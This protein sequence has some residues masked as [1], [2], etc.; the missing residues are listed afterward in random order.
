MITALSIIASTSTIPNLRC[1]QVTTP[2][3]GANKSAPQQQVTTPDQLEYWEERD[4]PKAEYRIKHVKLTSHT[5]KLVLSNLM[6]L[7]GEGQYHAAA[8]LAEMNRDYLTDTQQMAIQGAWKRKQLETKEAFQLL[9]DAGIPVPAYSSGEV[10][11]IVEFYLGM[12]HDLLTGDYIR[13]FARLD[14]L[15][16]EVGKYYLKKKHGLDFLSYENQGGRYEWDKIKLDF[17][18]LVKVLSENTN[19]AGKS[20]LS[21]RLLERCIEALN[22]NADALTCYRQLFKY[23]KVRNMIAHRI[24]PLDEKA[25]TQKTGHTPGALCDEIDGFVMTL[26]CSAVLQSDLENRYRNM[27]TAIIHLLNNGGQMP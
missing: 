3:N 23:V 21:A 9:N 26:L 24:T 6:G 13:F 17:P 10:A 19:S 2:A 5:R 18:C 15:L 4:N 1:V 27:N 25:M 20:Y 16:V 14:P 8:R 12:R 11:P 7:I 22:A